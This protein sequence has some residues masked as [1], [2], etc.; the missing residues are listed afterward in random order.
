MIFLFC[1][2]LNVFYKFMSVSNSIKERFKLVVVCL[3]SLRVNLLEVVVVVEAPVGLGVT[4]R[5]VV[6]PLVVGLF[7]QELA[8]LAVYVKVYVGCV[9]HHLVPSV[10]NS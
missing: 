7:V 5:H 9:L 4:L 8:Q 3:L 2:S 6:H 10:S 1:T